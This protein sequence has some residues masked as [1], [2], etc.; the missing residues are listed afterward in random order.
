M[1]ELVLLETFSEVWGSGGVG[2]GCAVRFLVM[3]E[4]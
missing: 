1:G 2:G 4:L 3:Q